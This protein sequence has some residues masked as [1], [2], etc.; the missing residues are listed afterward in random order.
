MLPSRYFRSRD[1]ETEREGKING[2]LCEQ[3]AKES[4]GR[5]TYVGQKTSMC[6]CV[7]VCVFLG[8]HLWH[9]EV[10][11][12]GVEFKLQPPAYTTVTAT[13]DPK[14]TEQG[15]GLNLQPQRY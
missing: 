10:P 11:R 3:K 12:L 9:V 4:R 14:P 7:C 5:D 6:L 1:T 2:L 13:P 8:V 15:Q